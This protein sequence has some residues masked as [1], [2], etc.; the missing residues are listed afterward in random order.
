MLSNIKISTRLT[1]LLCF[2]LAGTVVIGEVGLYA[3]GKLDSAMK[4][5]YEDRVLPLTQL[6]IIYTANL[7]N[8]LAISNAI[9]HPEGMAKYIQEIAQNKAVIDKQW[10]IFTVTILRDGLVDEEDKKLTEKFAEVRGHFVEQGIKPIVAAMRANDLAEIKHLQA[11]HITPLTVP[12]NESLNA[13]IEMQKRDAQ[14]AYEESDALLNNI[15][16]ISVAL[17]L[18]G[19]VL[20]GARR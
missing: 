8:R 4:T 19:T 10:E 5:V 12:L 3:S 16:L 18:L 1:I 17:I 11:E 20:G 14:E 15:R 7:G 13:L 9:N 2:L 6:N